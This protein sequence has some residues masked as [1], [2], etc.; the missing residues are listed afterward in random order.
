[1][2]QPDTD[3]TDADPRAAVDVA[4]GVVMRD[5]GTV[6]LAQ[7]PQG[8]AYAGWWEFP[9]GKVE[10]GESVHAAL[11]RELHEELG[12]AIEHSV[13]WLVRD[14]SYEHARV[15]LHFR[16][17]FDAVGEPVA[18]E[19]QAFRWVPIEAPG[20][21]PLLPATVPLM[22]LLGLPPSY[23]ISCAGALGTPLFLERLGAALSGGLRMIQLR[24]PQMGVEEFEQLLAAVLTQCRTV[25]ARVLVNSMH[26]S[27]LWCRADGV[28]LRAAD[29]A[30]LE[31]RP[32]DCTWVG[33]SC[34]D[35][36]ELQ[37]AAALGADFAVL[38]P[39]LPT[40]SHPGAPTLGWD[41]FEALALA[42]RLPIYALGGLAADAVPTALGRGAHG[43]AMIRGVFGVG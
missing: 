31:R 11:V 21:E 30:L 6:L 24:E 29:A 25:G 33:V 10:A 2:S 34:H 20:V 18:R 4:V 36:V 16:R 9:G 7:R 13:P 38:G 27:T 41:G 35:A 15:R 1:M 19:G 23:G 3:P 37:A 22:R 39:V 32:A 14:H 17:V 42:S 40:A 12:L 8:K 43:V 26:P 28:H 5:E